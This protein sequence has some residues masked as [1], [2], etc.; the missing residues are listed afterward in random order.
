MY[1]GAHLRANHLFCIFVWLTLVLLAAGPPGA[2]TALA[3]PRMPQMAEI[4]SEASAQGKVRVMVKFTA[5]GYERKLDASRAFRVT[6]HKG[7]DRASAARQADLELAQTLSTAADQV[8]AGLPRAEYREY[9]RFATMPFVA[10]E[11]TEQGLDQLLA[12]PGVEGI[13]WDHPEFLPLPPPSPTN[14]VPDQPTLGGTIGIIGADNVWS[15]GYTGSG[16]YVAI[17]D[18]GIRSTHEFFTGKTIVEACYSRGE[19]GTGDCPSGGTSQTGSGSA[20]HHPNTYQGWDHGTHVAGIAAGHRANETLHGV[21]KDANIIAVQVF[22]KIDGSGSVGSYP[23]DQVL[24]LEYIYSLRSTYNIGAVNMSLGGGQ[25]SD[26][27]TCDNYYTARTLAVANLKAVNIAPV[28][29]SGNDYYCGY[30]GNPGCISSAVAVGATTDADAETSFSNWHEGMLEVFAPG[31][32][33]YSST[34]DSDSSYES[35]NGTSMA[36]PHVTGAFTLLRQAKPTASV[37]QIMASISNSGVPVV[38]RCAS[39]GSKPRI[40]MDAA[41]AVLTGSSPVGSVIGM[42]LQ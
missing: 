3:A 39:G 7:P 38:T 17:L 23:S 15:S 16:W 2:A 20:A 11:L 18:S 24:G 21:A 12:L 40:Q 31:Y 37:D 42:L 9:A 28:I 13:Y 8:F 34:G 6:D 5:P 27:A 1:F 25:Y 26:Q 22:S 41:L 36:A 14:E 33:I 32:L 10:L 30:L 29:S 4:F 19:D 35:W